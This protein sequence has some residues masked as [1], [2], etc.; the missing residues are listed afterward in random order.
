MH[1]NL[2]SIA[3]GTFNVKHQTIWRMRKR[4]EKVATWH[5][6]SPTECLP[7]TSIRKNIVTL[8]ESHSRS[9]WLWMSGLHKFPMWWEWKTFFRIPFA[10]F[11]S[12]QIYLFKN[13]PKRIPKT[14]FSLSTWSINFF[15]SHC[16]AKYF[17]HNYD[18]IMLSPRAMKIPW[19]AFNAAC[20]LL[21][22]E[23][24]ISSMKSSLSSMLVW[25]ITPTMNFLEALNWEM[26]TWKFCRLFLIEQMTEWW[27]RHCVHVQEYARCLNL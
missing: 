20:D 21:P 7:L 27:T 6:K 3:Y 18:G 26:L 11:M 19:E 12:I 1:L 5:K 9:D 2:W 4:N 22:C 15:F 13:I 16:I 24:F 23:N 10:F 14:F 17:M 25:G 8:I